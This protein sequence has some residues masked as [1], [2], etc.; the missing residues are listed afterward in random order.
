MCECK[1]M[2]YNNP[3]RGCKH[4][5]RIE[6]IEGDRDLLPLLLFDEIEPDRNLLKRLGIGENTSTELTDTAQKQEA[7]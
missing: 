2:H 4:L 1:D 7:T 6:F 3:D 5:R